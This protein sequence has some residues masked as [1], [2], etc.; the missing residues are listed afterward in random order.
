[1]CPLLASGSWGSLFQAL[2]RKYAKRGIV[3]PTCAY[4]LVVPRIAQMFTRWHALFKFHKLKEVR[5]LIAGLVHWMNVAWRGGC[6][7]QLEVAPTKQLNKPFAQTGRGNSFLFGSWEIPWRGWNGM[8]NYCSVFTMVNYRFKLSICNT[9][10]WP[11][12]C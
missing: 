11:S 7:W 6:C 2:R 8:G 10:T 5:T 3:G 1:M 4:S 12:C 9:W